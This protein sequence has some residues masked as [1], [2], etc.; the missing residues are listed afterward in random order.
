MFAPLDFVPLRRECFDGSCLLKK[1]CPWR[2][3]GI[4]AFVT[5]TFQ[6]LKHRFKREERRESNLRGG[7]VVALGLEPDLMTSTSPD[8]VSS[9]ANMGTICFADSIVLR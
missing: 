5:N 3:P 8:L 7:I 6:I 2:F 9:L 4:D 1:D